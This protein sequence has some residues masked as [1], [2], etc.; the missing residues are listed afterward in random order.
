MTTEGDNEDETEV[1]IVGD[2]YSLKGKEVSTN[3]TCFDR[4]N[5]FVSR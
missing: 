2:V 3:I 5:L 1:G 4:K